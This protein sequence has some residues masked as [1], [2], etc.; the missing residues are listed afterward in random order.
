VTFVGPALGLLAALILVT[1]LHEAGHVVA[2]LVKGGRVLRVQVGRG[3]VAWSTTFRATA[4][5]LS[6]IPV[7]GRIRYQGIPGG[8]GQAVVAVSGA[9]ANLAGAVAAFVA[10]AW[11]AGPV[12]APA[13][14][15]GALSFAVGSASAWFWAV[16]GAVVEL[17]TTG[18]AL[19]LSA[20]VRGLVRLVADRPLVAFPY[21]LGALSTLWAALNLI[22]I[23]I[24]ETDG[25][26]IA[27]AFW[28]TGRP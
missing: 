1:A 16:P 6:L 21:S 26:H 19:E 23:P 7:G 3:P 28:P 11:L 14:P 20:A 13:A 17:V 24:L 27:R 22:P 8:S 18:R 10:A 2:V 5:V 15:T 4:L 9:V 12:L 25:W